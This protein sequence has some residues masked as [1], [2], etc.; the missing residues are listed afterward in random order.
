VACEYISVSRNLNAKE[1]FL[2]D[3]K[4]IIIIII[5]KGERKKT[6]KQNENNGMR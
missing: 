4:I 6:R 3:W 1:R 2:F 5:V